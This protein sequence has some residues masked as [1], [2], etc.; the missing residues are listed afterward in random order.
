MPH[1]VVDVNIY[2]VYKFKTRGG[3]VH[4]VF[5]L[6]KNRYADKLDKPTR[7]PTWMLSRPPGAAYADTLDHP[8]R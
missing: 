3:F 4:F 2:I 7:I 8:H 1:L 5:F 6:R